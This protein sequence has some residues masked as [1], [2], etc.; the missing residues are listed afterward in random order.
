MDGRV[1]QA[2]EELGRLRQKVKDMDVEMQQ[3]ERSLKA[4]VRTFTRFQ[5]AKSFLYVFVNVLFIQRVCF[6]DRCSGKE[7]PRE[8]GKKNNLH[9][10]LHQCWD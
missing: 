7:S 1:V 9:L 8:L 4:E 2:E 10:S 6:S 5:C 3:N